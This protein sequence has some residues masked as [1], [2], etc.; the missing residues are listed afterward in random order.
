MATTLN[1]DRDRS[2]SNLC[3]DSDRSNPHQRATFPRR[4]LFQNK[5]SD[6]QKLTCGG[7]QTTPGKTR[8]RAA[9]RLYLNNLPHACDSLVDSQRHAVTLSPNLENT[10]F[11]SEYRSQNVA[12]KFPARASKVSSVAILNSIARVSNRNRPTG[13]GC[14][15]E[16]LKP[17]VTR[18]NGVTCDSANVA[19]GLNLKHQ[20]R[21]S[22]I[23]CD[24]TMLFG[25]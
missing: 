2:N 20:Y 22:C 8:I 25:F 13:D 11:V 24:Q 1:P 6:F 3:T 18:G 16:V 17:H 9:T 10:L 19:C 5:N 21:Y 7:L 12:V 4:H 15:F 23:R 14:V